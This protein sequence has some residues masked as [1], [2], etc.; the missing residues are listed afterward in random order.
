MVIKTLHDVSPRGFEV[1]VLLVL[2]CAAEKQLLSQMKH[3]PANRG[4]GATL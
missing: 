4:G 2:W 3:N 1:R